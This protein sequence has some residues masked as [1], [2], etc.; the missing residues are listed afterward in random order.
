MAQQL[1]LGPEHVNMYIGTNSEEIIQQLTCPVCWM[2]KTRNVIVCKQN[3]HSICEDCSG[4]Y[5]ARNGCPTCR[6]PC[7][8]PFVPAHP[9]NQ[10]AA[11][12]YASH[13]AD[14]DREMPE[15]PEPAAANPP[16]PVPVPIDPPEMDDEDMEDVELQQ[17]LENAIQRGEN[18]APPAAVAAAP[19]VPPVVPPVMGHGDW[20]PNFDVAEDQP[21]INHDAMSHAE[22][23]RYSC[24]LRR[25]L[26]KLRTTRARNQ[27]DN[28]QRTLLK[29]RQKG[30]AFSARDG[31]RHYI[32]RRVDLEVDFPEVSREQWRQMGITQAG[33]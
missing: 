11:S 1:V 8:R 6:A 20:V 30:R 16:P 7:P 2:V 18:P 33:W 29:I 4:R 13:A 14:P 27:V 15:D 24:Q 32:P 5:N 23:D 19:V 3:G 25:L 21:V 9:L 10:I 28:Y 22:R 26:L 17:A 12:L 31:G